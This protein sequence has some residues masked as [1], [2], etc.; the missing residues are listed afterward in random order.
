VIRPG[1]NP[2]E[3]MGM[4]KVDLATGRMERIHTQPVPGN[5]SA[6]VTGGDLLFWG[7]LARRFRAFDSDNGEILWEA[8]LG[9]IIQTSTITYAVDGRQYVAV[10]TGDG[11]SGTRGPAQLSGVETVRGHNA[12][13]VFA[14]PETR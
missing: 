8:V 3:F 6:L 14:L 12:I 5:G 11:A 7:D 9:G 13:Y 4:A 10:L 1:S 2:E